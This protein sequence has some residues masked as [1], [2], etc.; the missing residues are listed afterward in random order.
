MCPSLNPA[1]S[2]LPRGFH[3]RA[4]QA[5]GL[6]FFDLVVLSF[7]MGSIYKSTMGFSWSYPKSQTLTPESRAAETHYN[8]GLNYI[9]LMTDPASMVLIGSLRSVTSQIWIDLSLPP[10]ARYLLLGEI[11]TV[12]TDPS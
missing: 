11:E 3:T 6:Y 4:V 8:L 7:L 1:K 9:E 10:V 5:A 12:F 2:F